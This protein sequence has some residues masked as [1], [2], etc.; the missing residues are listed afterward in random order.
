MAKKTAQ[1]D[2]SDDQDDGSGYAMPKNSSGATASNQNTGNTNT[3]NTGNQNRRRGGMLKYIAIIVVVAVIVITYIGLSGPGGPTLTSKQIFNN[4]SNSSLNQTQSLFI[5]DLKKSENVSNLEVSY[6]SS[7]ATRYITQSSNL[8]I[9]ITS[10]QTIESYKMGNYNKTVSTSMVTYTNSKNGVV[11]AKNVSSLYYYN[12]NTTII[13]F[14]DTSYSSTLVTNSSLQCGSGDQGESFIEETPFTAVN[15]SSL[16]YLVFNTTVTYDGAKSI[17]GRNCDDFIISN[18]TGSNLES[19]YSVF[20]L[21]ID[22]Q[23]GVPLY[24]NETDITRGVPSSFTF[25]ATSVSADVSSS[26]FVIPQQY[27]N[28]VPHSII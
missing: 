8:T 18:A 23:Y 11:I 10:N 17:A 20:N 1:P 21:C 28:A 14:N 25:T 15:V 16:A 24:F 26:E 13:C 22:T 27:L 5:N 9:A 12:T 4:V 2:D 19:N 6:F 3:S 7:N